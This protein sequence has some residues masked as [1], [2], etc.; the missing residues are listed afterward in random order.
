[1]KQHYSRRHIMKMGFALPA[2]GLAGQTFARAAAKPAVSGLVFCHAMGTPADIAL[3]KAATGIDMKVACW[4]SNT[5]SITKF[6][7]G[8]G[9]SFDVGNMSMQFIPTA[10]KRG[11]LAPLDESKIPNFSQ[12][13]PAFKDATYARQ[14]GKR[15]SVPFMFG[16]D[17]V[18]Y[19]KKKI[20]EI[21]SYGVLYDDKYAGQVALRDDPGTSIPQTALF[22]GHKNPWRL[23]GSELKEVTNFL[24]KKKKNFRKLWGGF[25][26][27]VSLLKSGEVLAVGDG[28]ISM[29]WS[30]NGTG[31]GT[32]FAIATPKEK[33]L[34]WTH[35]WFLPK[36][37]ASRPSAES[38]YAFMNWSIGSEQTANMGRKVGYV[39]P[40]MAGLKLLTPEEAKVIG[41]DKY[42]NIVKTGLLMDEFP[43]NFQEWVDAWSRF[44][45]A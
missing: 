16:Y 34:V 24:I 29:A 2:M 6:A 26:E 11:M 40:S 3:F 35:D 33:A 13:A 32:D 8:A 4:V 18:V 12:L 45:S 23:T 20:G 30:L 43:E 27:A 7:S 44:K 39:S 14:G 41:Y 21:D 25:A 28:W 9:K 22:L 36:E 42:E 31:K 37:A 38:V 19:N 17:S 15:Y 10:I 5:D 1:M